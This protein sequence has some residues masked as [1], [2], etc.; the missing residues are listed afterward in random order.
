[1][2]KNATLEEKILAYKLRRG[3]GLSQAAT[4]EKIGRASSWVHRAVN[5]I[6]QK[7]ADGEMEDPLKDHTR[8]EPPKTAPEKA[9]EAPKKAT[10][11]RRTRKGDQLIG[12][13]QERIRK[14]KENPPETPPPKNPV[15][16][17]IED[18]PLAGGKV[19]KTPE[20]GVC[21]HCKNKGFIWVNHF[22]MEKCICSLQ[23]SL[24]QKL[25]P[26][27][28][29]ITS[30]LSAK[31]LKKNGISIDSDLYLQSP[32]HKARIFLASAIKERHRTKPFN[33]NVVADSEILNAWLSPARRESF[34]GDERDAQFAQQV[35]TLDDLVRPPDLLIVRLGIL[36]YKNQAMAGI[37]L[38][39]IMLRREVERKP[40]WVIIDPDEPLVEGHRCWSQA[41]VKYLEANFTPKRTK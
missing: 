32:W 41:L 10:K 39:S 35:A 12:G 30:H 25:H 13:Q 40:T 27:L 7:V 16:T 3:D 20:E 9:P 33:H 21:P 15:K 37:L 36:G 17:K 2:G 24:E 28:R 22:D 31:K 8:A 18:H 19:E 23:E 5:L 11:K 14:L 26:T 4:G 6:E 38:E 29:G 1:M 34:E